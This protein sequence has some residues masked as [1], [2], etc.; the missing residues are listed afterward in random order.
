MTAAP[1]PE[2]RFDPH[3]D[4]GD[5][6]MHPLDLAAA[7][8]RRRG[9]AA[10]GLY[11]W[12]IAPLLAAGWLWIDA[13]SAQDRAGLREASWLVV[14]AMVWRW[15]WL[16]PMQARVMR[17]AGVEVR[18]TPG[19]WATAVFARLGAHAML[20]WGSLLILPGLIGFYAGSFVTVLLLRARPE[21]AVGSAVLGALGM[22]WANLVALWKHTIALLALSL[23]WALTVLLVT[24]LM[25]GTLLPSLLGIDT[26]DVQLA[27]RGPAWWLSLGILGFV[28]LDLFWQVAAVFTVLQLDA[29]RHGG[30]LRG[31][32]ATLRQR[33][34]FHETESAR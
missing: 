17:D 8:L 15:T 13:A 24:L 22:A 25:V 6:V 30:D 14:A 11:A 2:A 16:V 7:S 1:L 5:G 29:R 28:L 12:S 34:A 10:A 18:C 31:R 27:M 32:I 20:A 23:V 19:R 21:E 9:A 33:H 26:T 3:A 4:R